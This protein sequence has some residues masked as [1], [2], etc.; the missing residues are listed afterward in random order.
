MRGLRSTTVGI[1]A[2][3][4]VAAIPLLGAGSGERPQISAPGDG[5]DTPPVTYIVRGT[6][7]GRQTVRAK[8]ANRHAGPEAGLV[9]TEVRYDMRTAPIQVKDVNDDGY[10]DHRDLRRGDHLLVKSDLPKNKP[11]PQPFSV[12]FVRKLAAPPED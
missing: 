2:A 4:A 5:V 11:G 9:G 1:V 12:R 10:T 8:S 3:A 7:V 6:Y